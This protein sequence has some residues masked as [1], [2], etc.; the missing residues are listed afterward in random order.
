MSGDAREFPSDKLIMDPS[1]G[2]IRVGGEFYFLVSSLLEEF[3][4][5]VSLVF[6][7]REELLE[8]LES[9]DSEEVAAFLVPEDVLRER[10]LVPGFPKFLVPLDL[11]KRDEISVALTLAW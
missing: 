9:E 3:P 4:S 7:R 1:P 6:V 10:V 11:V 5:D 8:G 2:A